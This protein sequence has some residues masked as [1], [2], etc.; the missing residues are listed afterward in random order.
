MTGF[1]REDLLI[2][3]KTY[4]EPSAKYR[5]TTC[6]AALTREGALKRIFPVRFR[7]FSGEQQ[8]K[9]WEWIN[10][11]TKK[12]NDDHRPESFK[13]DFDSVI[14]RTGEKV[15]TKNDWA[16][17]MPW[18]SPHIVS[19]FAALEE[20]RQASGET[21]GIIRPHRVLDLEITSVKETE[22]T[23]KEKAKLQSEGLF[24][25]DEHKRPLLRKLP[26]TFH[27]RYE[28][29]TPNGVQVLR[30]MITDW[31]AGA[32]FWNC[33]RSHGDNWEVPFRQKIEE[34]LPS[35]DL[36]FLLGTVHRFPDQWLIVGL[37]YPPKP[38]PDAGQL[39]LL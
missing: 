29:E 7:Y 3:T 4:P 13:I 36:M 11:N 14:E 9:K 27:Y 37:F 17:R 28:C 20:R 34:E 16:Q 12:S 32:L 26:F 23:E 8:F 33:L 6:V 31:E 2:L 1:H 22:W 10:V 24:D 25:T 19:N 39:S 21:L 35:K 5:E 18:L 30:H 38:K 15:D